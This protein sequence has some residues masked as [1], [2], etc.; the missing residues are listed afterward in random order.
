MADSI[1]CQDTGHVDTPI[2]RSATVANDA[3]RRVCRGS[4]VVSKVVN[5]PWVRLGRLGLAFFSPLSLRQRRHDLRI[6]DCG[7]CMS[8]WAVGWANLEGVNRS[9]CGDWR[10]YYY[11][12]FCSSSCECTDAWR[13][14][15][16]RWAKCPSM[17]N[18][19][20]ASS[21]WKKR[22]ALKMTT[23]K[24][25]KKG[26]ARWWKILMRTAWSRPNCA[27]PTQVRKRFAFIPF[28]PKSDQFQISS[29]ASPD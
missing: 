18:H 2:W 4:Q 25:K 9:E 7:A 16:K 5:E 27:Y 12:L 26:R 14:H 6:G 1:R 8:H 3:S 15:R 22:S 17:R 20:A 19:D 29:A 21:R 23:R 28:I 24:K 10:V 11:T 13:I